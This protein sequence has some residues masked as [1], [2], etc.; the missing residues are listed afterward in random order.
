V[1]GGTCRELVE[2]V[3]LEEMLEMVPREVL[4]EV[5]MVVVR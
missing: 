4:A 3:E 5:E 2:M 1:G